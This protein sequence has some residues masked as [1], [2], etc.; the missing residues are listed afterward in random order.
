[1]DRK[2]KTILLIDDELT[3]HTLARAYLENAGY[4]IISAYDGQQGLEMILK[5]KPNLI[6][7][8]YMMPKMYGDQVYSELQTNSRFAEVAQTPVIVLTARD[9]D[10]SLRNRFLEGGVGAYLQKPFGLRELLNII[11]NVFIVDE[12][13]RKNL[14]L[15]DDLLRTREYL[16]S[17]FQNT[18]IGILSTDKSGNILRINSYLS[19]I[20][21]ANSDQTILGGNLFTQDLFQSS[22]L[23][24]KYKQ[25]LNH[26]KNFQTEP[27]EF[28][29]TSDRR[30]RLILFGVPLRHRDSREINGLILIVQDVTKI[31]QREHELSMLSQISHFMQETTG[32]DQLL[33]LILTAITAGCAMGFSRAMILLLNQKKQVLEGRMGVGPTTN[34][35]AYRIWKELG[36]ENIAL[37]TFLEKYGKNY[38]KEGDGYTK[39]VKKIVVPADSKNSLFIKAIVNNESFP[40]SRSDIKSDISHGLLEKLQL[41]EFIVVPLVA[42]NKVI[43]VVVADNQFAFQPIDEG[44]VRLLSLF[45]NQAGL[46]IERAETYSNLEVEKNKLQQAYEELKNTQERLLHSERLATVGKMAAQVAHEIRNPLVVIG[47]FARSIEKIVDKKEIEEF[48]KIGKIIAE[49]VNR[50][51]KVLS[52]VLDFS[53]LSKP[54]PVLEDINRIIEESCFFVS[55][56]DEILQKGVQLHKELDSSIPQVLM[57]PQQ[58]KQVLL[59]LIQNALHSMPEGGELKIT[60]RKTE[61]RM[62]QISVKDSGLGISPDVLEEMFNP[63]FTTKP[64]G[65]G[66]G[67]PISQK[68]IHN[69]GGKIE[70]SSE[71]N[72]GTTF[73]FTLNMITDIKKFVVQND[74]KEVG[75]SVI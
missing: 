58:I 24:S 36:D 68:I 31:F 54:Q 62:I 75:G 32:L 33:H 29:T 15:Q 53:R 63:F 61:D 21:G 56:Q 45:A 39:L 12:I 47:G 65:T 64:D 28:C 4:H 55:V 34:T 60:S 37:S 35:E 46:A 71:V 9:T 14:Q 49:E 11:E 30:A 38:P 42:K 74:G 3:M 8:D 18:P 43:G 10:H 7:L 40:G 6:L 51:E 50:L 70:V 25:T 26:G 69:H 59:N 67:L 13:K 73:S 72:K 5:Y 22:E 2:K 44:R 66:L 52:N 19:E 16:E 27:F 57:D 20:L 17:L 48:K 23:T 1:M 41:D